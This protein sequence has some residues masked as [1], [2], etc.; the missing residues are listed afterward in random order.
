MHGDASGKDGA[1][2]A[3]LPAER[4][5]AQRLAT[6]ISIASKSAVVEA[7]LLG[8]G[9]ALAV[10]DRNRQIVATNAAYVAL[11][12]GK[13]A[14]AALGL[15]PGESLDCVHAGE[16]PGGCGTGPACPSCGAAVALLVARRRGEPAERDCCL[17]VE[18]DG[19]RSEHVFRARATPFE[20]GSA[21]FLLLTLADVSAERRRAALQRAFLHD[22]ANLAVGLDAAAGALGDVE[23][24]GTA[25]ADIRLMA[26]RLVGEVRLQRTLAGEGN[27]VKPAPETLAAVRVLGTLRDVLDHHPTARGRR[28]AVATAAPGPTVRTDGV[29]LQHVLANMVVNALEATPAGGEVRLSAEERPAGVAFRVWNPGAIPAA[30]RPRIFQRYFTTKGEGRGQGTFAMR[31]F[32]EEHLGGKVSFET[33]AAGGTTFE[34][35]L[36][37][38]L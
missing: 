30:V 37:R 17:R 38:R 16:R 15:R 23:T 5:G 6:E 34:L 13:D 14:I 33:S 11:L 29:I 31:L 3:Y 27:G 9:A 7:L 35:L 36:P 28:L 12:G 18:R 32:G 1:D 8:T 10:V 24:D 4:T 19:V 25:A 2:T 26:R 20:I 21:P 22:L